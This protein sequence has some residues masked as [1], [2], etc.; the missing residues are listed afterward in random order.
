MADPTEKR[1]LDA[2]ELEQVEKLS[3]LGMN[4]KQIGYVIGVSKST[5]ERRIKDQ[6]EVAEAVEKGRAMALANVTKSAYQQAISG[7]VPAMTMFW[8]KCRA[9][10]SETDAE[11]EKQGEYKAPKSLRL[12]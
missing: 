2:K 3:G 7:K 1:L 8:L 12:A 5:M 6:P 11:D 4:I 10:W 9:G